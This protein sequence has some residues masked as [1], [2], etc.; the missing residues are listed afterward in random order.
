M[1]YLAQE[2][3]AWAACITHCRHLGELK[4]E[5]CTQHLWS[6]YPKRQRCH[7]CP[8]KGDG[9]A[10]PVL[11]G[12]WFNKHMGAVYSLESEPVHL[13]P[14][15]RTCCDLSPL[16]TGCSSCCPVIYTSGHIFTRHPVSVQHMLFNPTA[17]ST[18]CP[19]LLAW[20]P[21][22]FSDSVEL[23]QA[24]TTTKDSGPGHSSHTSHKSPTLICWSFDLNPQLLPTP[25]STT[26]ICFLILNFLVWLYQLPPDF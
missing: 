3:G 19:H 1:P 20:S 22:N 21:K 12:W 9:D 6:P 10:V 15:S 2:T 25:R 11:G 16:E 26:L 23:I 8:I 17:G 4:G 13:T 24:T 5:L 14:H 18:K 7:P